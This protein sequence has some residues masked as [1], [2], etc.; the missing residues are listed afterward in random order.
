MRR[1]CL[2]LSGLVAAASSAACHDEKAANAE[3][4]AA[5]KD[6][7]VPV[8]LAQ[9][10]TQD[11]PVYLD[12]LGS[13]TGFYTVLIRSQVDG[14]IMRVLFREGQ[15]VRKGEVLAQIDPRP[16]QIQLKQA[17]AAQARDS[18]QLRDAKITLERNKALYARKLVP[19]QTVDDNQASVDQL[20]GTVNLD[21]AQ[22]DTA[23]LQ[24]AYCNIISPIDGRTGVRLVDPGNIVHA[25]DA[26][27]LVIITQL[28]PIA[29]LFT[30]PQDD[31][32]RVAAQLAKGKLKA[33][34]YSRDDKVKFGVG[35][36]KLIDNQ[37]N[38]TT[39]TIRVKAVFA[40]PNAQLWP[41][42]FVKVRLLLDII[43]DALIIPAAAVQRGPQGTFVYVANQDNVVEARPV[44]TE[45]STGET[46]IVKKGL[47]TGERVVA[48]G[49]FQLHAGSHIT[50]RD[51]H[52]NGAGDANKRDVHPSGGSTGGSSTGGTTP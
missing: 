31:L 11:T 44:E 30:L 21:E 14:P 4:A 25:T 41:N 8:A 26:N 51:R 24:L 36:V 2:V 42:Q 3:A 38:Q 12:G 45:T 6:R 39:G 1:S 48:D 20:E 33:E 16:Y 46:L 5:A 52:D 29:V 23:K 34:A 49:Q 47:S 18:A 10:V 40:N 28:D 17:E 35:E 32:S 13:V 9:V 37:I 15:D 22:M 19:Q 43:K 7:P 27:G 50:S